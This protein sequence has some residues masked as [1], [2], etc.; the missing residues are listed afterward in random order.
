SCILSFGSS[1]RNQKSNWPL[2]K[3]VATSPSKDPAL[4]AS[5]GTGTF[6]SLKDKP[7]ENLGMDE[8]EL[9]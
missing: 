5:F 4:Q 9:R 8:K 2:F 7:K 3:V 1:R 6:F